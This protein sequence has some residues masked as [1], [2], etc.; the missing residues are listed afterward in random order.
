LEAKAVGLM[1][2]RREILTPCFEAWGTEMQRCLRIPVSETSRIV[3]LLKIH[4]EIQ[5]SEM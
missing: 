1:T 4:V 3:V 5:A 2:I